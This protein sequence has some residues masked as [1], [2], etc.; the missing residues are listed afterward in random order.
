MAT[1]N[2][3][4]HFLKWMDGAKEILDF[5]RKPDRVVA[6][7]KKA[8]LIFFL[9]FNEPD[10]LGG[11][12][13]H[14]KD[15]DAGTIMVDH[16]P[17]PADIADYS[18]SDTQASS[19]AELV[20]QLICDL[21]E[22]DLVDRHIAECLF[23][24]IM[25]DT[26]CF[27][28][29]SSNPKT[30]I[31]IS[32]LLEQGIDK[33]RIYSLIYDN[34]STKRMHLLGYSLRDKM[35]VLPELR[36]SYI[37]LSAED[38]GQYSHKTGD[39]EGFVNYPFTIRDIRITAL[40]LERKDHIKISFRSK[41]DFKINKFAQKYFNGGGHM[42]AAGGESIESLEDTLSRFEELIA[43]YADEIRSLP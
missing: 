38:L 20:Y 15:L 8:D 26:G 40:F 17:A 25:T 7:L 6:E 43:N 9:D 41:G 39:T 31:L 2:H 10:R 32:E 24:G 21:D 28:F 23:A 18:I 4:P 1:P 19:T 16:H 35:V 37:S 36:T 27:S 14:L 5:D 11:I 34:Y 3:F 22:K 29:N 42:N 12:K 13:N 33:D 30:Y